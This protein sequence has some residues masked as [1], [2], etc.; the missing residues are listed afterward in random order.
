[1]TLLT[2][3]TFRDPCTWSAFHGLCFSVP[4]A[5]PTLMIRITSTSL[6]VFAPW[7]NWIEVR[8]LRFRERFALTYWFRCAW[9][10]SDESRSPQIPWVFSIHS[11]MRCWRWTF[12]KTHFRCQVSFN[13]LISKTIHQTNRTPT[14]PQLKMNPSPSTSTTSLLSVFQRKSAPKNYE[15]AF[16]QL[17]SSYGFG[18]AVPS[19]PPKSS[20]PSKKSLPKSTTSP[21]PPPR[22]QPAKDYEAAFAQ[23]S[24]SYGFG[25]SIPFSSKK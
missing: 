5:Q 1:M 3:V 12:K 11:Q 10:F 2:H 22:P 20:K 14:Q 7:F 19:L 9:N 17:S 8:Y 16:G 25:G 15:S 6:S 13:P 24:S 18:G 23:L 21:V 4:A